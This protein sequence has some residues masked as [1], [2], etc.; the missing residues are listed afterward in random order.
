LSSAAVFASID[1]PETGSG[2][3]ARVTGTVVV[4]GVMV[5]LGTMVGVRVLVGR[6]VQVGQ[7]VSVFRL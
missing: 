5:A 2:V 7:G 1:R 4:V 3:P 6:G